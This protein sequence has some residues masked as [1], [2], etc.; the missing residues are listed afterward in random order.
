MINILTTLQKENMVRARLFDPL[1]IRGVVVPNRIVMSPMTRGF[2]PDGVP[3][4]QVVDYYERR[5]QGGCGLIIT[6]AVGVDHSGALGDAGLGE[7]DIP[8]LHGDAALA[9]WKTAV[10]RVHH[11]GGKIVPQLWHQG[12]MRLPGTGP[13]PDAPVMTPSGL[14]GPLGRMTSITPNKI[15]TDPVLGAPMTEEDIEAVLDAFTRS[16]V[17]AIAIGFDGIAIH[18]GHGY[19]VD[20]FLWEETNQRDDRWGGDRKRR[21]AF[22]AELVR[23]VRA[24][25]GPDLPIFFRFSDWKQQDFRARLANNPEELAEVLCPL[26]EAGVDV[27]DASVRYFDKAAYDGSPMNL[28]GWAKKVTDKMSVAVGGIGINKGMYESSQGVAA[29]DNVELLLA[30]FERGEFDLIAVGRAILGDPAW[31]NRIAKHE[32]PDQFDPAGLDRLY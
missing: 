10:D 12:A 2:S 13:F 7:D 22:P 14:W 27:F 20:N 19:L 16:A 1:K 9:G 29:V 8:V 21:S 11:H 6:E 5:A 24:A 31:A 3:T 15:P 25:I 28:A 4:S 17:N 30:R 32:A 26:A 18:G 23:R